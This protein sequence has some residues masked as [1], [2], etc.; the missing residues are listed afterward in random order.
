MG[1]AKRRKQKDPDFGK[2]NSRLINLLPPK[3]AVDIYDNPDVLI[4][5]DGSFCLNQNLSSQ[6]LASRLSGT[7]RQQINN[8]EASWQIWHQN[9][10]G[11]ANE[12][13]I[14][15]V[16]PPNK[17]PPVIIHHLSDRKYFWQLKDNFQQ[18]RFE[19]TIPSHLVGTPSPEKWKTCDILADMRRWP[20]IACYSSRSKKEDYKK[21]RAYMNGH[22]SGLSLWLEW[23]E[24]HN[25]L[26]T[27]IL[28]TPIRHLRLYYDLSVALREFCFQ[29]WSKDVPLALR[30]AS[31]EHLWYCVEYSLML[32]K[33]NS[34]NL[35][36]DN[37]FGYGKAKV[38]RLNSETIAH[39]KKILRLIKAYEKDISLIPSEESLNLLTIEKLQFQGFDWREWIVWLLVDDAIRYAFDTADDD[40]AHYCNQFLS[41]YNH[42]NRLLC[43]QDVEED[44]DP[45]V[46][47]CMY[48]NERGEY[49]ISQ[50]HRPPARPLMPS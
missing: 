4:G 42:Y 20:A 37:Y 25:D 12:R 46:H 3:K 7:I 41:S 36:G 6:K 14:V 49:V 2:D 16:N 15:I 22:Y 29:L 43:G 32:E 44:I 17:T 21:L 39:R 8:S 1:E 45:N 50:H 9:S 34:T 47:I 26:E 19:P 28:R 27:L 30:A 31:K 40:L 24:G 11:T 5:D 38:A 18:W 23:R 10:E 35:T 48:L 13:S 33:A